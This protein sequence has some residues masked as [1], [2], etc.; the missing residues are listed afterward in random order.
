MGR[1]LAWPQRV[2]V[3]KA[4]GKAVVAVSGAVEAKNG[5]DATIGRD[6]SERGCAR[7]VPTTAI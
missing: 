2:A 1:S 6:L 3:G 4:V 5:R 7:V